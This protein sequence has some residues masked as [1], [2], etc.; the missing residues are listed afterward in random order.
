MEADSG[1]VEQNTI[2]VSVKDLSEDDQKRLEAQN[3]RI[4]SDFVAGKLETES[5]KN[6]D[7]FYKRNQTKF[8]KDRNWTTREFEEL[9]ESSTTNRRML[10]V[11]CGVG[12]L[13][14]PLLE[15]PACSNLFIYACDF[16]ARAVE[17]VKAN[18]CYDES[19]MKAFQCDITELE[20][21]RPIEEGSLDII[22]MVFVLS[23]IHP[24]KFAQVVSNLRRLLKP[25]G[26]ILFRDYGRF[27]MAQLRFKSGSK[28][29][30]NFYVRQDGTRYANLILFEGWSPDKAFLI[31][32]GVT[33]SQSNKL[34]PYSRIMDSQ[35]RTT[36][37]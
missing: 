1:I 25:G 19:Q 5:R 4:V 11:G 27:D 21:L 23:A 26:M 9:I 20:Q 36:S 34:G 10:E 37:M 15:N 6:W 24:S 8:F 17:Y 28:I 12:N 29:A 22:T 16:S 32:S 31:I 14:Y 18:P 3:S 2:T 35:R 13:V 33:S 7:L 30:D